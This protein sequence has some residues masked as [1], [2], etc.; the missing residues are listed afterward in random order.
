MRSGAGGCQ[1]INGTPN[2]PYQNFPLPPYPHFAGSRASASHEDLRD[3]LHGRL[4]RL[5]QDDERG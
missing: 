5:I 2:L 4:D 1:L 3:L